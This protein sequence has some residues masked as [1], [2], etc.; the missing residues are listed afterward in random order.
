MRV[1]VTGAAGCNST[2]TSG[3]GSAYNATGSSLEGI[4]NMAEKIPTIA[5]VI[6]AAILIGILVRNLGG[7][8]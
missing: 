1:F 7:Q 4:D 5:L 8:Q 3:C 2:V 6:V